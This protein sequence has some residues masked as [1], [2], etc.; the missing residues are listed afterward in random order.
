MPLPP[1]IEQLT[2]GELLNQLS[3]LTVTEF[4]SF[5]TYVEKFFPELSA[6]VL[7]YPISDRLIHS[8]LYQE[9]VGYRAYRL[10]ITSPAVAAQFSGVEIDT[11]QVTSGNAETIAGFGFNRVDVLS[12]ITTTSQTGVQIFTG[13]N[14]TNTIAALAGTFSAAHNPVSALKGSNVRLTAGSAAAIPAYATP[15]TTNFDARRFTPNVP[16]EWATVQGPYIM[17][18]CEGPNAGKGVTPLKNRVFGLWQ[19]VV[20]AFF[21]CSVLIVERRNTAG[22]L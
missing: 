4:R 12:L 22:E 6:L 3:R 20:N 15:G 10:Q 1:N 17:L 2:F 9:M 21:D 18:D 7:A 5:R 8:E 11:T 13:F 14:D 16:Y 19:N